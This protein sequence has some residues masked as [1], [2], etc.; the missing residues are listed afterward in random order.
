MHQC[1]SHGAT[2][3]STSLGGPKTRSPAKL[4]HQTTKTMGRNLYMTPSRDVSVEEERQFWAQLFAV[5]VR[6]EEEATAYDCAAYC[7]LYSV[8]AGCMAICVRPK[9]RL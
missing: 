7:D 9:H 6:Y 5:V 1:T 3:N 4:K 8:P 2:R